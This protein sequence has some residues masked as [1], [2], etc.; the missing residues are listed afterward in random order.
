MAVMLGY[1]G[2]WYGSA[3]LRVPPM[4]TSLQCSGCGHTDVA[5][6]VSRDVFRCTACGHTEHADLNAAKNI[7]NRGLLSPTPEDT[8]SEAACGALCTKQGV[9]AGNE[10]RKARSLAIHGEG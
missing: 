5:S 2:V 9:E 7:R 1:K 4:G 8:N 3:L 6:R 10:G